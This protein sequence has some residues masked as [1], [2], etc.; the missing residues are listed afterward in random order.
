MQKQIAT[1][2]DKAAR[3]GKTYRDKAASKAMQRKEQYLGARVPK[4]LRDQVVQR[5]SELGMP[6]SILIREILEEAVSPSRAREDRAGQAGR[7]GPTPGDSAPAAGTTRFPNVLGWEQILLN[8]SVDCAG[9]GVRLN[10]GVSI[11]LGLAG[12]GEEHVVLCQRC[13]HV[14]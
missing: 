7:S 10:P 4:D 14:T 6:V 2:R 12:P 3:R 13:K 9:C 11:T 1:M 5:A 8:R